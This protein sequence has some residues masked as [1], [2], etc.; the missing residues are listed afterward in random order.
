MVRQGISI[1]WV[2]IAAL[3]MSFAVSGV[4]AA[5]KGTIYD[6]VRALSSVGYVDY[7]N[8][9]LQALEKARLEQ[10]RGLPHNPKLMAETFSHGMN[11]H[12]PHGVSGRVN[13]DRYHKDPVSQLVFDRLDT[14]TEE[15][16]Q[17]LIN[18]CR[19][20]APEAVAYSLDDITGYTGAES[21]MTI[22]LKTD[23][24]IITPPRRN[25]TIQELEI[26]K[27]KCEELLTNGVAVELTSQYVCKYACN[28]VLAMKRAPDGTWSDK[29]FCINYTRVNNETE[30]DR[31]GTHRAE[32]LLRKAVTAKYL[33]ALDLR[34]GFH[35]IPMHPDHVSKTA[36][37]WVSAT[38]PPKL[39]A[40]KRMP[41][42][43]KNAPAKFQRVMDTELALGGCTEFAFAYIDDVIIASNSW[44]E[45]L[46]H[47]ERVLKCL[48]RANLKI[49]PGK[50]IFGTN[51]V[52]YLGHNVM[53]GEGITMNEAKVQAISAL[54]VP[55]NLME[56]RSIL[57]FLAYYRHF[58]PGFSSLAAPL[59][60][61]LKKN[62]PYEWGT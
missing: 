45:H 60:K 58:I 14:L 47:V 49:H 43:L 2:I 39:L 17:Q 46:D 18:L 19:Q 6:S 55:T 36:F 25:F 51:I 26:I 16:S 57:G 7:A 4:T 44:E 34:S 40:Y 20:L 1:G 33:T 62:Q 52:E 38:M 10:L 41:F 53:A 13:P 28:P 21:D 27:E 59:T 50:S 9:E 24:A 15:Q 61:L 30:L 29:R 12:L 3:L 32:E 42:G 48:I 5:G 31:Y 56:L 22:D 8:K 54:P 37:W 11:S 23:K 35:Q